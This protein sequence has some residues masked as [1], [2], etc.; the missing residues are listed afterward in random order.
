MLSDLVNLVNIGFRIVSRCRS[1]PFVNTSPYFN[2]FC[3]TMLLQSLSRHHRLA[4]VVVYSFALTLLFGAVSFAPA[5]TPT[6]KR[7]GALQQAR[8]S[9]AAHPIGGGQAMVIGGYTGAR[10]GALTGTP[11]ASTE[12]I[13]AVNRTI[14]AGAPMNEARADFASVQMLDGSI[15]VV[16]GLSS[17]GGLTTGVE[18]YNPAT[19]QWRRAGNLLIARRQHTVCQLNAEEVL[20]VG[21]RLANLNSITAAEIVNIRT[22]QSRRVADFPYPIN[23]GASAMTSSGR[24]LVFGGRSGGGDSYRTAAVYE[25]DAVGNQWSVWGNMIAAVQSVGLFRL[26][27]GRLM[28]SGGTARESFIP[29]LGNR[30]VGIESGTGFAAVAI[31]QIDRVWHSMVEW[32]KDSILTIGGLNNN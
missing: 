19:Q 3:V 31:M 20:V 32:N 28:I 23:S 16:S 7:F 15:V 14:K 1:F 4:V 27:D 2:L 21:G 11:L 18:V 10:G 22:G 25:Y 24:P 13:D 17:S 29:F 26:S 8:H 30:S 6:W 5:S 12:I 9:F